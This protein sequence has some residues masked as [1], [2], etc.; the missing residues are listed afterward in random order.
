MR[1][2]IVK[3]SNGLLEQQ[4]NHLLLK[5]SKNQTYQG[6]Q[7]FAPA[8]VSNMGSGFDIIG[9]PIEGAGDTI[10]AYRNTTLDVRI[11]QVTGYS[12]IPTDPDKNVASHAVGKMLE[13]LGIPQGFD[14]EIHKS[15]MPGSGLGSSA[16]SS[17]AAVVAV[18]ELLDRP[19]TK[20]ELVHFAM[21]G[22]A[23][24]S[25]GRHADNVAP[26]ILGGIVLVRSYNPLDIVNIPPPESMWT[27]VFHPQIEIRTDLG[28][29]VIMDRIA[30]KDAVKQWGNVGGLIAGLYT[31]DYDLIGDSMEDLIAEPYRAELIPGYQEMKKVALSHG[32]K[33]FTIS[34]SG[35]A[36]FAICDSRK[37][38]E[39]VKEAVSR[40]YEKYQIDFLTYIS[41]VDRSGTVVLERFHVES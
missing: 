24:V 41:R 25:G 18:N 4:N 26:A 17:A 28:R 1:E 27:M 38:A 34:G 12:D 31:S 13:S 22:E 29:S 5:Q 15:V 33:G 30:L 36:F 7:V 21:E 35:P 11:V 19:F 37:S 32:A 9:F 2:G 6:V 3:L 10:T 16:S 23:L 20:R 39:Q 40:E 8:T 14:L